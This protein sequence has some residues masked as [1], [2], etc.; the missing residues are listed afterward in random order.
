MKLNRPNLDT[1]RTINKTT[2]HGGCFF[3]SLYWIRTLAGGV[4]GRKNKSCVKLT[5]L[6]QLEIEHT[7][8]DIHRQINRIRESGSTDFHL[9]FIESTQ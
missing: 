4:T 1:Y 7:Y 5:Y 6:K 2:H 9:W 8:F 3:K